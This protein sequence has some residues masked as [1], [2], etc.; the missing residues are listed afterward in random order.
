MPPVVKT[1][2]L[3]NIVA[4]IIDMLFP[5]I[6]GG[7]PLSSILGLYYMFHPN[8]HLFQLVTYMFMHGGLMHLFFNM[9]ALWMF[10]RIMEQVW[11]GQRFLFYYLF[12]GLGAAFVQEVGQFYGFINPYVPT[13]GASGAVYGILL[14]FGMTFPN[15]RLFIIPIPFP[16]KAKYFVMFYA[17]VEIFEGMNLSDGVAHFAHLGGM[18]FGFIL[19]LY[20]RKKMRRQQFGGGNFWSGNAMR[21]ED[22]YDRG[23]TLFDKLK[24]AFSGKKKPKMNV[25]YGGG[26]R[27]KDYEYNSKKKRDNE[28]I[29][30]ILDKVRKDGYASLT[31]EEKN[32][33]FD[34]SKQ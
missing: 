3:L 27:E 31:T 1:L 26:K 32:R 12:C 6:S 18:L 4:F 28:E 17:A 25:S 11:G 14:A 29:D 21:Y 23:E 16:I 20:W 33:L 5:M 7:M 10:G 15:E 2:L 8:F 34:A 30:R 19:I 13:I 24:K 9:F 22:E